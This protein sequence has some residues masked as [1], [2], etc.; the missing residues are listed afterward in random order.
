M[1]PEP[2]VADEGGFLSR[3]ARRKA[4]ARE[5]APLPDA[6]VV[7]VVPVPA[8][9]SVSPP[10]QPAAVASAT[11]AEA[12]EPPTPAPTMDDVAQLDAGSDYSAFVAQHVDPQVRNA[13][14]KKL[15]F[16]DP[17]F[18]VMDG[19]DTYIDDYNRADPLPRALMRQL[20]Q[21]RSLG[22]LDDELEEQ[23]L[24]G[25]P[26]A[27]REPTEHPSH[28][29]ADLQLQRHDAAGRPDAGAGDDG[30]VDGDGRGGPV[31]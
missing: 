6:P 20:R 5:G 8:P 16:S 15:F 14:M 26:G 31:A 12:P 2:A 29:D 25:T 27:A 9:P 17:H 24:P 10:P 18:N 1:P 28:E 4:L 22:L 19:L 21:A 11:P 23:D 3:W 30:P 13:A 7:P